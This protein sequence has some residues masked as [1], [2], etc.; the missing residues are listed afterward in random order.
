VS[1]SCSPTPQ[2]FAFNAEKSSCRRCTG[3]LPL[4]VVPLPR[5]VS[6]ANTLPHCRTVA[7]G[8]TPRESS[9]RLSNHRLPLPAP[10]DLCAF[11]TLKR[12]PRVPCASCGGDVGHPRAVLWVIHAPGQATLHRSWAAQAA[13][14]VHVGRMRG[15]WPV[16]SFLNRNPFLFISNSFQFQTFK[17]H[18]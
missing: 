14:T 1:R 13:R 18:I 16:D 6:M 17:I 7:H 4:N 5:S 8:H 11:A 9:H 10:R 15:F 2:S 12:A 3:V